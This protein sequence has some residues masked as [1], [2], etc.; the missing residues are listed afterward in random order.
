MSV[1]LPEVAEI[2][3]TAITVLA[4]MA[5]VVVRWA[6]QRI[7]GSGYPTTWGHAL[8]ELIIGV[9]ATFTG[10][11]LG[12]IQKGV[13]LMKTVFFGF[14][15]VDIAE[16]VFRRYSLPKHIAVA[17]DAIKDLEKVLAEAMLEAMEEKA[18][19]G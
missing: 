18:G 10:L 1:P 2:I 12:I 14:F 3:S 8:A 17:E 4:S 19:G 6:F 16:S 15:S 5:G 7:R 9:F 13:D 11:Q